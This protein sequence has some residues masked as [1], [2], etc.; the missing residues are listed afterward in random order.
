MLDWH[1][2]SRGRLVHLEQGLA[3]ILPSGGLFNVAIRR[4]D[5]RDV[6]LRKRKIYFSVFLIVS[7]GKFKPRACKSAGHVQELM[8]QSSFNKLFN[9]N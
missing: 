6:N 7:R 5:S 9:E 3:R 8:T 2:I 4:E 1:R